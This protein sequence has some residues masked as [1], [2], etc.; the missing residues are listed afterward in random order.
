MKPKSSCSEFI[1]YRWDEGIPNNKQLAGQNAW[2]EQS[3]S[4]LFFF[5]SAV[6]VVLFSFALFPTI[7]YSCD[8]GERPSSKR[9]SRTANVTL[10]SNRARFWPMHSH[11]PN[12][13]GGGC[14]WGSNRR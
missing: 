4:T 6:L 7:R 3:S 5:V 14:H 9:R 2:T 11:G 1:L 10:A 12:P 13:K 8:L